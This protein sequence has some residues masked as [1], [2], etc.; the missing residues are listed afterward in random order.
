MPVSPESDL[1]QI[2]SAA[3][4][5]IAAFGGTVGR[6]EV[7]P[8]AFGIK[9]L[10]LLFVMEE[11]LGSTEPLEKEIAE[12]PEVNSVEVVDVRRAIG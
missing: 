8:V 5:K 1:E 10:N 12:I 3:K 4:E 9:A 2:K 11:K 7:S 6:E